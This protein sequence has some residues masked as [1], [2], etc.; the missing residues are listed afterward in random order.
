[1]AKSCKGHLSDK[2]ASNL[3]RKKIAGAGDLD[4]EETHRGGTEGAE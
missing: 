4:L 3:G 2:K 1:M